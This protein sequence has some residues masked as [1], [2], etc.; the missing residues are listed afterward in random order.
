MIAGDVTKNGMLKYSGTGN[1]RGPIIARIVAETGSNNINGFTDAG[2]WQEDANMNSIV[3]YLGAVTN[4]RGIISGKSEYPYRIPYLNNTYTSVVPGAYFGGKDGS[5]DGPVDIHFTESVTDLAIEMVTNELIENGMVDNI[6]F[7]LAWKASDT[8]IEQL[9]NTFASDFGLMP[10]GDAVTLNGIKYLVY[11][12]VTP[13]YL[14]E[15]WNSGETVTVMTFEK[16][17]GQLINDRLWIADNDFTGSNNGDYFV[18]N[19]GS[20]VTGII[21]TSTV[22]IDNVEAGEM[23]LYPNPVQLQQPLRA[24]SHRSECRPAGRDPGYDWQSDQNA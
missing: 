15:V 1:D 12:S 19:W 17:Y 14:P 7:T 13:G 8:E 18:S 11:V 5:N 10:Q 3:L 4:D 2:Y 24:V 20:D 21:Y 6:Q 22:G 16:E 23:K 9:L